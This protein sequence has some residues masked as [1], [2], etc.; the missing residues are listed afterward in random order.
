[1]HHAT[2]RQGTWPDQL[3]GTRFFSER[4][5]PSRSACS[6]CSRSLVFSAG[7]AI[8]NWSGVP[9]HSLLSSCSPRAFSAIGCGATPTHG[10]VEPRLDHGPSHAQTRLGPTRTVE[11]RRLPNMPV[12]LLLDPRIDTSCAEHGAG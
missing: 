8:T 3:I 7:E 10:D 12:R 6:R 5:R 11:L 2:C 4:W 1:M 9:W